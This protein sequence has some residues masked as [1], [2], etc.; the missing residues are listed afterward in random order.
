MSYQLSASLRVSLSMAAFAGLLLMQGCA[1]QPA[2]QQEEA[3]EEAPPAQDEIVIVDA[4]VQK[5]FD[6]ATELIRQEKYKE[7]I[8]ALDRVIAVEKRL[9]APYINLAIA[10]NRAGDA[11]KAEENLVAALKIDPANPVASNEHGLLLR[12]QGKFEE[13]R[14]AY[15]KALKKHPDYLPVIRNL[16]ILCDI[17][18]R[19]W[20]CALQ[21]FEKIQEINPADE[22]VKIWI[23]DL[24]RRTGG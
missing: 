10:H 21:Q 7:A 4:G 14:T 8:T 9:A 19:D 1:I 13:A 20:D 3:V 24:K 17:Y 12:K 6:A 15:N 23:A 18:L 22:Q 16:G 11:K 5:N 2:A